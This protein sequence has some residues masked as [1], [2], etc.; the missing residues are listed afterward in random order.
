MLMN[1][2][3]RAVLINGVSKNNWEIKEICWDIMKFCSEIIFKPLFLYKVLSKIDV[4]FRSL[5]VAEIYQF[6]N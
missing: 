2:G 4:I 5:T 6:S 3:D 1:K